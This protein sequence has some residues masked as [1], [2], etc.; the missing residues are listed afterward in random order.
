MSTGY[1]LPSSSEPTCPNFEFMYSAEKAHD[2]TF[3]V[4]KYDAHCNDDAR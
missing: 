3:D 4:K 1:I 2:T